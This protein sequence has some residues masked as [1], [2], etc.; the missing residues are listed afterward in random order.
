MVSGPTGAGKT[1]TALKIAEV[2][3]EGGK[4]LVIDT[5]KESALTYADTFTFVHLPWLPPFE[6]RELA[7]TMA[8][9]GHEYAVVIVDSTSHFWRKEGG[10]LDIAGGKFT[11]WKDARPA[12]EDLVQALLDCHAHVIL[13]ARSKMEHVQEEI[14]GRH[15]LVAATRALL[16][17]VEHEHLDRHEPDELNEPW[18]SALAAVAPFRA[19]TFGASDGPMPEGVTEVDPW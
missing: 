7:R 18:A 1:W 9:A 14:N 15:A 3:A 19:D 8:E 12:Q 4:I 13:C 2:L 6:P 10:T 11:G 17:V 16:A 5:E